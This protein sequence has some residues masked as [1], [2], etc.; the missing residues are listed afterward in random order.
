LKNILHIKYFACKKLANSMKTEIG[1][2]HSTCL[3]YS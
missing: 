2:P 3:L 1:T